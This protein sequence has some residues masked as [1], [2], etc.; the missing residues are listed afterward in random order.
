MV[1]S[2]QSDYLVAV[3]ALASSGLIMPSRP[4]RH[5][6]PRARTAADRRAAHDAVRGNSHARG[7]TWRWRQYALGYLRNHPL[8]VEC[9]PRKTLTAARHVDHI[10]AVAGPDDPRFW[11]EANFQA[12]CQPCHSA[13]TCRE[14]GGLGHRGEPG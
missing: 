13:K 4:A 7:Y 8:C 3:C 6:P 9:L 12:L 11:D 1:A 5:R 10:Q 2:L 14:D